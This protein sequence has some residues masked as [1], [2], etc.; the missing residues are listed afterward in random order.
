MAMQLDQV[1]PFGR[2]LDEYRAMFPLS[3][4]DLAKTII[5]VADGPASF[6]AE[7]HAQ[8]RHVVSADPLYLRDAAH[9]ERSPSISPADPGAEAIPLSHSTVRGPCLIMRFV[10]CPTNSNAV[11]TR[12]CASSGQVSCSGWMSLLRIVFLRS[13]PAPRLVCR[14]LKRV[15]C[16]FG[17]KSRALSV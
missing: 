8:G 6:N 2:A 10:P 3:P 15:A 4:E 5:G 13:T 7:M 1:V 17:T 11:G 9:R 14:T 16:V 12:C